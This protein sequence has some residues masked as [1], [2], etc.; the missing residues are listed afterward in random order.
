MFDK[1]RAWFTMYEM[2]ITWFVIGT[3]LTWLIVDI[4]RGNYTGALVDAIIVAV[5]YIYRPKY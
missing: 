5:N 3:F 2:E 4:G 1:I